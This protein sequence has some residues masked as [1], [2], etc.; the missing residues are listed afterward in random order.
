MIEKQNHVIF[1]HGLG[2]TP[3]S[4]N[5][6]ISYLSASV[7]LDCVPLF[8]SDAANDVTY[9]N[10][11]RRFEEYC[12]RN[13]QPFHLCGISL[14][15][16]LAMHYTIQH[17][18]NVRSLVLIAP[19]YKMPRSLL[20][21]QNMIFR[22]LPESHFEKLGLSKRDL[23]HLTTSMIPLTFENSLSRITCETQILCG[24]KDLANKAAASQLAARIPTSTLLLLED[25]GH[26]INIEA[27][28]RLAAI[29]NHFYDA[30][31]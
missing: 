17:T 20:R 1:L 4:W 24:E 26:E 19:Q 6:M 10:L 14:G 11:Y 21:L 3:A 30:E 27:P 2:Q 25:T 31:K 29:L 15:A 13:T 5:P 9:D 16:I 7:S 23:L 8:T 22:F 28:E 18:Q 12:E